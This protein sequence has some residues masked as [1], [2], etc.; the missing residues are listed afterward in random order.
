[1]TVSNVAST[2]K[3]K[4]SWTA[5]SGATKYTLYIYD[6]S[7]TLLT[8]ASTTGTSIT[9]NTAESAVTYT[10]KV[11]ALCDISA[12]TSAFSEAKS[13]TCDLPRPTVTASLNS[14]G[15]PV[16]T[17]TSVSGAV[18]YTV[19]IYD[20]D[21]T[22]LKTSSTTGTKLTHNTAA[23]GTSYSYCVVAVSDVS[24]ANSAKSTA[25]SIKAN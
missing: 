9:H 18:K 14:S 25:V 10:Y 23:S 8:T 2:G 21:G 24:A 11:K 13:R 4:I 6:E 5:I 20:A 12:A 16:L 17:W 7:G 19:Y 15:K 22:L 3:P 1:M